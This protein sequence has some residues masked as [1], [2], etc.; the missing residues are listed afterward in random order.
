MVYNRIMVGLKHDNYPVS[1]TYNSVYN[2]IMVGLKQN[3]TNGQSC[4]Q[5]I[6][7]NR[8]MVGLKRKCCLPQFYRLKR[9]IIESW[10]D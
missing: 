4:F 3:Q 5:G 2:R 10:W 6:V 8:I 9:F 1:V 7:Y